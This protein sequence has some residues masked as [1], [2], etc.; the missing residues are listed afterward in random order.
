MLSGPV[1]ARG[2][3][4]VTEKLLLETMYHMPSMQGLEKVIIDKDVIDGKSIQF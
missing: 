1:L 4:G 3:R 2:L